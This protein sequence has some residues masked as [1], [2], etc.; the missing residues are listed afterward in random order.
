MKAEVC[1]P[2]LHY[3]LFV[4]RPERFMTSKSVFRYIF[5]R[6]RGGVAEI[7]DKRWGMKV[8]ICDEEKGSCATLAQLVRRQEPDCEVSCFYSVRQFLEA[9]QHYDILLLDI[10]ME[11]MRGM[12]AAR[13]LRISGED[14]LLIFVTAGRE[15]A[16]EAFEVSAFH[17]L[18]KPVAE[19]KFCGVF[20]N[21]CR[22]VRRQEEIRDGQLFFQTKAR[23]FTVRKKEILY[24]ESEK[25]KVEIHT[26]KENITIYATM[27]HMEEQLGKGFYRCHRGYLVNMDYVAGYG[28]GTI[29]L[30]NGEDIYLAREK[31]SDFVRVYTEYLKGKGITVV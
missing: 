24:I 8:A 6:F 21:A 31:Y 28:F 2:F 19:E 1:C 15:Y 12:E 9:R 7:K 14:T 11:G 27:K 29:R 16:A 10:Q 23:N 20:E 30:Q 25:R 17:Y 22:A 18:L 13:A 3:E 4:R 5:Q 26:L